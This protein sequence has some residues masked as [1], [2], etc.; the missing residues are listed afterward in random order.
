MYEF[1]QIVIIMHSLSVFSSYSR[2]FATVHLINFILS[3]TSF[4]VIVFWA[5][6]R[7]LKVG[8]VIIESNQ[9]SFMK[10]LKSL[11]KLF[12]IR[13]FSKWNVFAEFWFC[14]FPMLKLSKNCYLFVFIYFKT[15]FFNSKWMSAYLWL[16]ISSGFKNLLR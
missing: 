15:A 11:Y 2:L 13:A 1:F 10:V 16:E 5:K 7:C 6:F 3:G 8:A 14:S 9:N 4:Y 12:H